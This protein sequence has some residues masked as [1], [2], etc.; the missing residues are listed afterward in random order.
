MPLLETPQKDSGFKVIDFSLRNID[1]KTLTL[2]D[3][4]GSNGTLIMFICNHCPY[5]KAVIDRLVTDCAAL[6]KHGV[7]CVAVMP[8]DTE[9]YPDDSFENM[10][11]FAAKHGFTFP[12][13]IDETQDVARAYDAV[14][15]PDIFGFNAQGILEYRGRVD[16]AGPKPAAPDTVRE[17]FDAMMMIARTAKGPATQ[18]PSIGCSIKWKE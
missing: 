12:Y 5:V 10:K 17:M 13:V 15:T 7:G 8:N 4:R 2:T 1:G 3:V 9:N 6:Q 14:C 11:T 16:S 18:H